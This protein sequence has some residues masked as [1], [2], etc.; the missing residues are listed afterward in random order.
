MVTTSPGA[1]ATFRFTGT[2][3]RYMAPLWAEEITTQVRLDG[4]VPVVINLQDNTVPA[5]VDG[6]TTVESSV[7]WEERG[8][9][10]TDHVLVI[11]VAPGGR[12]AI[13]DMLVVEQDGTTNTDT[14]TNTETPPTQTDTD[15]TSSSTRSR[16]AAATSPT[17]SPTP[18][19]TAGLTITIAVVCSVF[20]LLF[21]IGLLLFL[22]RRRRQRRER[23]AWGHMSS[24]PPE[25]GPPLDTFDDGINA[26]KKQRFRS[27]PSRNG[28]L[29]KYYGDES[30]DNMSQVGGSGGALASAGR[31][32][33]S[34]KLR[35]VVATEEGHRRQSWVPPVLPPKNDGYEIVQTS[36]T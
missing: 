16:A 19:T 8:L 14:D 34:S 6:P 29:S 22:A 30:P 7:L 12:F 15:T 5:E 10:N 11:E 4:G 1:S 23:E 25:Q 21:I 26:P 18:E 3:I 20:G 36:R 17:A 27:I 35:Q 32:A 9:A 2:G 13:V 31:A 28:T 24:S 33:S